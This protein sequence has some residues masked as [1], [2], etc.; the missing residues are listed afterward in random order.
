VQVVPRTK[1]EKRC[2]A[3]DADHYEIAAY[4]TSVG[5][6]LLS[7]EIALHRLPEVYRTVV[8]RAGYGIDPSW[9]VRYRCVSDL[10]SQVRALWRPAA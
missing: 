6:E 2:P 1:D 7:L 4:Y 8:I 5:H 3:Y 10:R 9:P